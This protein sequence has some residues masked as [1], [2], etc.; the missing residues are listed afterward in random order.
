MD[1]AIPI[2]EILVG[3]VSMAM[4]V[5]T[6]IASRQGSMN[7]LYKRVMVAGWT[8]LAIAAWLLVTKYIDGMPR[9]MRFTILV[10]AGV[11]GVTAAALLIWGIVLDLKRRARTE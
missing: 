8:I 11:L 7:S 9:A 2:A 1:R 6:V 4:T 10:T 3:C 5:V